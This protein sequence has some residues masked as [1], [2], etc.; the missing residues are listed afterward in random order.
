MFKKLLLDSFG[1]L[2]CGAVCASITVGWLSAFLLHELGSA[3]NHGRV[4]IWAQNWKR[5]MIF[6]VLMA[7]AGVLVGVFIDRRV[8][9]PERRERI[10][11]NVWI[12]LLI[13]F[14]LASIF[15]SLILGQ[16]F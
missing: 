11:K 15:G 7:I 8:V 14:G 9:C 16:A 5:F 10:L 4:E 3:L 12:C 6:S 1:F 13:Y 2:S